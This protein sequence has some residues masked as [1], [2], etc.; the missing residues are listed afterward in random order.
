MPNRHVLPAIILLLVSGPAFADSNWRV[1]PFNTES[2]VPFPQVRDLLEHDDGSIWIATWGGG[3]ARVRDAE[4]T[5]YDEESGLPGNW[6]RCLT[7]DPTGA[8]WLGTADGLARIYRDKIDVFTKARV[9]AFPNDS[10]NCIAYLSHG[11]IWVGFEGSPLLFECSPGEPS[12]WSVVPGSEDLPLSPRCIFESSSNDIWVSTEDANLV[13]FNGESWKSHDVVLTRVSENSEGTICGVHEE[14]I[15]H[16]SDG[17]WIAEPVANGQIARSISPGPD[18]CMLVGTQSGLYR[19]KPGK[20]SPIPLDEPDHLRATLLSR[21]GDHIY[22]GTTYGMLRASR[23]TWLRYTKTDVGHN[24]IPSTLCLDSAGRAVCVHEGP[25]LAFF[26]KGVWVESID[27]NDEE[28]VPEEALISGDILW[29]ISGS[30]FYEVS[31]T[32]GQILQKIPAPSDEER[33]KSDPS[34]LFLSPSGRPWCV[35]EKAGIFAL[36]EDGFHRIDA[37]RDP[38]YPTPRAIAAHKDGSFYVCYR[39][40]D[41]GV[42][43]VKRWHGGEFEALDERFPELAD[44]DFEAVTCTRDGRVWLGTHDGGIFVVD[45]ESVQRIKTEDGLHS[46]M[47][48]LIRETSDGTIWVAYLKNGV[49]SYRDGLWLNHGVESGLPRWLIDGIREDAEGR[50]WISKPPPLWSPNDVHGVFLYNPDRDAPQTL[51][52]A[53]PTEGVDSHGIGVFTF[54]GRDAWGQTP[55]ARL[56]F[57]WRFVPEDTSHDPVAWSPYTLQTTVLTDKQPLPSGNYRFEVRSVDLARNVDPTPASVSFVVAAPIWQRPSVLLPVGIL[58]AI[59]IAALSYGGWYQRLALTEARARIRSHDEKEELRHQLVQ[60]QKLEA[61]GTFASGLA[62]DI[63]NALGAIVCFTEAARLNRQSDNLVRCLDGIDEVSSQAAGIARSLLTFSRRAEKDKRPHS[64]PKLVDASLPICKQVLGTNI[65]ARSEFF[66]RD[67]WAEVD[68]TQ[69]QQVFLNVAMNAR[70]AM[71]KGGEFIITTE[72]RTGDKGQQFAAIMMQ[73]SGIGMS[74]D[75]R[76]RMFEPFFTTKK[77]GQGTGLGLSIIHGIIEN[78]C[79]QVFVESCSPSGTCI[80]I[81][82]PLCTAAQSKHTDDTVEIHVHGHGSLLIVEDNAPV[83]DLLVKSLERVGF[84]IHSAVD[85]VEGFRFF[86]KHKVDAVI[87]DLDLPKMGGVDCV[88]RIR[89]IDPNIPVIFI[90]GGDGLNDATRA[91]ENSVA[92]EK[93][94]SARQLARIVSESLDR[95]ESQSKTRGSTR[96]A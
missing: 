6:T 94:F 40:F 61:I 21:D 69:I 47:V 4:W 81:L 35:Y 90:S 32:D 57:S 44:W 38:E 46:N 8:V 59:S 20:W 55:K 82:L 15:F 67:L 80:T 3:L 53:F 2:G 36:E 33:A 83:R 93:P 50:L 86:R 71:P 13:Q 7:A 17:Q 96:S 56:A 75:T 52:E 64:I 68:P 14:R 54:S 43:T 70:D 89:E 12:K 77:R 37:N 18:G 73:D 72:Q 10:V 91:I 19:W 30:T 39:N 24:L 22:V 16:F 27:I 92:I 9:E 26:D 85:G 31:L 95:E 63:N 5:S 78:H 60:S 84:T 58:V 74:E 11:R 34:A 65:T 29:A 62:H 79:G 28:F 49:G 87:M 41:A 66:D 88:R 42:A 45:G 23:P 1:Q 51:V 76:V 25:G 48:S